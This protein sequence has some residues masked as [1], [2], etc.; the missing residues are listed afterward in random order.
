MSKK[1][2]AGAKYLSVSFDIICYQQALNYIAQ[3]R[4]FCASTP[5]PRPARLATPHSCGNSCSRPRACGHA[6]PLA[7]HP[8]PCPPC[9]V[10][11]QLPCHCARRVIKSFRCADLAVGGAGSEGVNLSCSAICG[12]LLGCGRHRCQRTC[13][14]GDCEKCPVVEATRCYC[15]KEEKLLGCG[16]G[17]VKHS[18]VVIN[19]VLEEWDGR[20]VC[21]KPCGRWVSEL[22]YFP[23][24]S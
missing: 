2:R 14:P 20:F 24:E 4:C 7:C 10:T 23:S 22:C 5:D 8:G 18:V 11:T 17:E 3:L 19:G 21:E 15:G 9:A 16:E 12:A 13:H 1:T 6:C